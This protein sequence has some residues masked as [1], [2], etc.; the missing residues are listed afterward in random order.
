MKTLEAIIENYA[1]FG[2]KFNPDEKKLTIPATSAF[3]GMCGM[4]LK[5]KIVAELDE[6]EIS[7]SD[8]VYLIDGDHDWK[9]YFAEL[10][11]KMDFDPKSADLR[12]YKDDEAECLEEIEEEDEDAVNAKS[13]KDIEKILFKYG[14]RRIAGESDAINGAHAF[15]MHCPIDKMPQLMEELK[16]IPGVDNLN[17]LTPEQGEEMLKR[18][19]IQ[20][21]NTTKK[22]SHKQE[23]KELLNFLPEDARKRLIKVESAINDMSFYGVKI[24]NIDEIR[25]LETRNPSQIINSFRDQSLALKISVPEDSILLYEGVKA[26]GGEFSKLI[27]K[28]IREEMFMNMNELKILAKTR[29]GD[30]WDRIKVQ[31]ASVIILELEDL[32]KSVDSEYKRVD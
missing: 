22:K 30:F 4:P 25:A 14:G 11:K 18:G 9:Q 1:K 6:N 12:I 26:A 20:N 7:H 13:I 21:S 27:A 3:K 23:F 8:F 15:E 17:F 32:F 29:R 28:K 16:S 31:A 2:V 10:D 5:E 24:E 19:S